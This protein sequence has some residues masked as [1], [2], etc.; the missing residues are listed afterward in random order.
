MWQLLNYLTFEKLELKNLHSAFLVERHDLKTF[1][2]HLVLRLLY[3]TLSY[4]WV[5]CILYERRVQNHRKQSYFKLSRCITKWIEKPKAC[6]STKIAEYIVDPNITPRK[7]QNPS[8]R[9]KYV[10]NFWKMVQRRTFWF[11]IFVYDFW[12]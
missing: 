2:I 9:K 10:V 6:R 11:V 1:Q 5:G 12:H 8:F 7:N 3:T 4:V